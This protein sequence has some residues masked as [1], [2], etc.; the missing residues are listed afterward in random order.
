MSWKIC[1]PLSN[2]GH[3]ISC[4][5]NF[6]YMRQKTDTIKKN[7]ATID[8]LSMFIYLKWQTKALLVSCKQ[9]NKSDKRWHWK[10]E[11]KLSIFLPPLTRHDVDQPIYLF[12]FHSLSY[13]GS[14]LLSKSYFSSFQAW[15]IFHV[16]FVGIELLKL[17]VKPV[18]P[19]NMS[20]LIYLF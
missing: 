14:G 11:A 18:A 6:Q 20:T 7:Y 2:W 12:I 5:P 4:L 13:S 17:W 19:G 15:L 8:K 9:F 16:Y 10:Y 1:N 3:N